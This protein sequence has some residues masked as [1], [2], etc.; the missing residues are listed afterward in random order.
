M[1]LRQNGITGI[2]T[3]N[4]IQ[5]LNFMKNKIFLKFVKKEYPDG[6][7]HDTAEF[8]LEEIETTFDVLEVFPTSKD[9]L[10]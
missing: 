8:L 2:S 10:T 1:L 7:L 3:G 5:I 6:F 4:E 9:D